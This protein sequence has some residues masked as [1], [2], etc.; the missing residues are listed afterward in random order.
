VGLEQA[1]TFQ[2]LA[3]F[4]G[5]G[6]PIAETKNS[7]P[8]KRSPSIKKGNGSSSKSGESKD[9]LSVDSS[10]LPQGPPQNHIAGPALSVR[11]EINLSIAE[12]QEVYDRIFRNIKENLYPN[13]TTSL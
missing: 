2:L 7:T 11:I 10:I 1:V 4:A 13:V 5:Y 9:T 12:D 3:S 8:A 6:K